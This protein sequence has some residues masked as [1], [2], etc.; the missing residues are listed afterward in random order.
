[1]SSDTK[2]WASP[3][4]RDFAAEDAAATSERVEAETPAAGEAADKARK[5]A[6]AEAETPTDVGAGRTLH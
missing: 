1:M 6:K 5:K 2:V 3:A 4:P